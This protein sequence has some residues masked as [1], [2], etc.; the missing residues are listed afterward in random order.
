MGIKWSTPADVAEIGRRISSHDEPKKKALIAVRDEQIMRMK[1][2]KYGGTKDL[3]PQSTANSQ[4][5]FAA[6]LEPDLAF[7]L[8]EAEVYT[9]KG[10]EAYGAAR[11]LHHA[12]NQWMKLS[13]YELEISKSANEYVFALTMRCRGIGPRP[14]YEGEGVEWPWSE[15]VPLDRAGW[16]TRA[17]SFGDAEY[18]YQHERVFQHDLLAQARKENESGGGWDLAAIERMAEN[19][20]KGDKVGY[21]VIY[22][23]NADPKPLLPE[24]EKHPE[25]YFGVQ[26][27]IDATPSEHF[28]QEIRKPTPHYGPNPYTLIGMHRI[29]DDSMPVSSMILT[30]DQE[31]RY[32]EVVAANNQSAIDYKNFVVCRSQK[33]AKLI[34]SG[35]HRRVYYDASFNKD[36]YAEVEAGGLNE[37]VLAQEERSGEQY[38]RSIGLTDSE[39]GALTPDAKA[40][41]IAVGAAA[42]TKRRDG[43]VNTFQRG[44]EEDMAGILWL[45]YHT[46]T[47]VVDLGPEAAEEGKSAAPVFFGGSFDKAQ[48]Q[49]YYAKHYPDV[50]LREQDIEDGPDVPFT[51]LQLRVRLGSMGRKSKPERIMEVQGDLAVHAA[52]CQTLLAFPFVP[53]KAFVRWVAKRSGIVELP[54]FFDYAW[55]DMVRAAT[56]QAQIEPAKSEEQ[57]GTLK[58]GRQ[59]LQAGGGGSKAPKLLQ[60]QNTQPAGPGSAPGA[61]R[62]NAMAGSAA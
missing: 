22:L 26:L 16:D 62:A 4:L 55:V 19:K 35:K 32:A 10:G 38:Y 59:L 46:D 23:P 56:M 25:R 28:G 15:T 9:D 48:V 41:D 27:Y 43:Q 37:Q 14:G 20:E 39:R 7:Q 17:E 5:E 58:T 2:R 45:L 50:Q 49:R 12:F 42:S 47:V 6:N 60:P 31:A 24:G 53:A 1:G 52:V 13:K 54:D 44:I 61:L 40:T 29:P 51:D 33:L 34:Q 3:L 30:A 18:I 8:P 21:Y 57:P 36:A 11:G